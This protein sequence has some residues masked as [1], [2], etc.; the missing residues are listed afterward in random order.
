[1]KERLLRALEDKDFS[2][3]FQKGGISFL[4]RIGGQIMGF[5]MSFVIAYY[6]GAQGLG[7]YILAIIVLRIFALIS[8]LGMDTA[9]LRF[10]AS[11]VK[12]EKW[13]SIRLFRKKILILI[14]KI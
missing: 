8:K 13:E 9:S 14:K 12:Q 3:L 1:M 10:I 4:I 5:L 2:E 11:F 6:Y 7:N